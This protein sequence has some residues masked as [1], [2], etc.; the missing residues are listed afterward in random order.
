MRVKACFVRNVWIL[1]SFLCL[2]YLLLGN[3]KRPSS[4]ELKVAQPPLVCIILFNKTQSC[5]N[6]RCA[7]LIPTMN[8]DLCSEGLN[9][10][11]F[12]YDP[13]VNN[14]NGWNSMR[15]KKPCRLHEYQLGDVVNC[16]DSHFRQ[17]RKLITRFV[18][19]GDS[20]IRQQFYNFLKVLYAN[21][22]T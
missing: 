21:L 11:E 6:L 20:R 19:V 14:Q 3:F 5:L 15:P 7:I 18:F 4:D 16:L 12:E 2:L 8:K 10:S 22:M 1:I 13:I 9:G 17:P